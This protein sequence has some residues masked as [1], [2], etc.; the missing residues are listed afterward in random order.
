MV[1]Y[2]INENKSCEISN[3]R[4]LVF[5]S[6]L[7]PL[8]DLRCFWRSWSPK[9]AD[10]CLSKYEINE[11]K[12]CEVP[13]HRFFMFWFHSDTPNWPQMILEVVTSKTFLPL[14]VKNKIIENKSCE[15]WHHRFFG[16]LIP[17]WYPTDIEDTHRVLNA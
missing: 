2:W 1:K 14:E 9:F 7:I 10:L 4:F 12:S 16:V 6:I 11:N 3:L 8:F 15:V 17:F 13:N 5:D